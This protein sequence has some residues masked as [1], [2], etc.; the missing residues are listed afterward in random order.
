[1]HF[2]MY[3]YVNIHININTVNPRISPRGL[4]CKN[5]F[6]GGGLFEGGLFEGG[7]FQSLH[8]PQKVDIKNEI[9]FSMN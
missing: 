7:L 5:E 3:I 8:F 2:N 4:I 9:I 6:L 1:M